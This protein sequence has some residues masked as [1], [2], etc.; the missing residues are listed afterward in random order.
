MQTCRN[1]TF[2]SAFFSMMVDNRFNT[3]ELYNN[4]PFPWLV[5]P[6]SFPDSAQFSAAVIAQWKSFWTDFFGMATEHGV[7]VVVGHWNILTTAEMQR[8]YKV[9]VSKGCAP[10]KNA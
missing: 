8:N 5:T 3:L 2:W 7:D 9:C 6:K 4:H 1:L 10:E